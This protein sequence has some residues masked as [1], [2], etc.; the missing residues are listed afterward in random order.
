[1]NYLK[2]IVSKV[3]FNNNGGRNTKKTQKTKVGF[4]LG[5]ALPILESL[6]SGF[7]KNLK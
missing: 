7:S 4:G 6:S 2:H 1:M 3:P 5:L